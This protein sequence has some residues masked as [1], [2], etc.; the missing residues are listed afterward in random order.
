MYFS[1]KTEN[2]FYN[3]ALQQMVY[4]KNSINHSEDFFNMFFKN[5]TKEEIMDWIDEESKKWS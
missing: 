3:L 5:K 4:M 2:D 1:N